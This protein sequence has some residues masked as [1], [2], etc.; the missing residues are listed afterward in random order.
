M[1]VERDHFDV[2]CQRGKTPSELATRATERLVGNRSV[3]MKKHLRGSFVAEGRR[4]SFHA[5]ATAVVNY[6]EFSAQNG[7]VRM[8][9]SMFRLCVFLLFRADR[10]ELGCIDP[11]PSSVASVMLG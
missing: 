7:I 2:E 11:V 6:C 8:V 1:N 3:M 9:S 10:E 4:L 5:V